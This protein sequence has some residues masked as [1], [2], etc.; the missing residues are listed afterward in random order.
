MNNVPVGLCVCYDK[1]RCCAHACAESRVDTLQ[2]EG[3][4]R[5]KGGNQMKGVGVRCLKMREGLI[6]CQFQHRESTDRGSAASLWSR[7]VCF[8][9]QVNK[10]QK[11]R[12]LRGRG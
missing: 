8:K 1:A 11:G 4:V 6:S 3:G 9:N 2:P 7:W 12:T 5:H 10:E